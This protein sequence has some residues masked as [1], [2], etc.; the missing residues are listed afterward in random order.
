MRLDFGGLAALGWV[1]AR[2]GGGLHRASVRNGV[3]VGS[4][5]RGHA[6]AFIRRPHQ[7]PA[8]QRLVLRDGRPVAKADLI[9]LLRLLPCAKAAADLFQGKHQIQ[10]VCLLLLRWHRDPLF[11]AYILASHGT[12]FFCGCSTV[13]L[14]DAGQ[15]HSRDSRGDESRP[16]CHPGPVA[17][18]TER[19]CEHP[20]LSNQLNSAT[21]VAAKAR[22]LR[23]P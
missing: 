16:C 13:V 18:Y 9:Q 10:F 12:R 2:A 8:S 15:L 11:G 23:G 7:A 20:A 22:S 1:G 3:A 19:S 6:R 14:S 21:L 5:S 4:L 17:M